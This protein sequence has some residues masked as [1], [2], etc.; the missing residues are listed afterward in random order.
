MSMARMVIRYSASLL[1]ASAIFASDVPIEDRVTLEQCE[2]IR[3]AVLKE[4]EDHVLPVLDDAMQDPDSSFTRATRTD[5]LA[6]IDLM[7]ADLKQCEFK[8]RYLQYLGT[9]KG[10]DSRRSQTQL[11]A[12]IANLRVLNSSVIVDDRELLAEI[13]YTRNASQRVV[14]LLR[15][16]ANPQDI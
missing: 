13:Q 3:K 10:V 14:D 12:V 9:Y 5:L 15:E 11:R 16:E 2:E 8:Q 4:L 7:Y 6:R 1:C